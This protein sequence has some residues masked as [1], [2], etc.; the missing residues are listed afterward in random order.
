MLDPGCGIPYYTDPA[1]CGP[2]ACAGAFDPTREHMCLDAEI[3]SA[4]IAG[5]KR[6]CTR[7]TG[8]YLCDGIGSQCTTSPAGAGL[9][10]TDFVI[11]VTAR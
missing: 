2:G 9:P 1:A 11:Y 10:D 8:S 6:Y 4:H 5:G 7:C 3:P